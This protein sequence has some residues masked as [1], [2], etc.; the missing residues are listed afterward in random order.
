ML[1]GADSH[2]QR[3]RDWVLVAGPPVHIR[4]MFAWLPFLA[5]FPPMGFFLG[6]FSL[7]LGPLVLVSP[8]IHLPTLSTQF[9]LWLSTKVVV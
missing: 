8:Q 5:L 1:Q 2:G 9:Q 7:S 3:A 4:K 6:A